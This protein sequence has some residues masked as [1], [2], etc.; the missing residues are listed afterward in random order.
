MNSVFCLKLHAQ[1]S[2]YSNED[3]RFQDVSIWTLEHQI[4]AL[5]YQADYRKI[6]SFFSCN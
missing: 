5:Y 2:I 1:N 4:Y 3:P 6:I